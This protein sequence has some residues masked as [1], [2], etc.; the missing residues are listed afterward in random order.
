MEIEELQREIERIEG[1]SEKKKTSE[2]ER[3]EL[4]IESFK[5]WKIP[6]ITEEM[7]QEELR[8]LERAMNK[9]GHSKTYERYK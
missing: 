5:N 4:I 9:M 7:I 1:V 6:E 3:R 8:F 2:D